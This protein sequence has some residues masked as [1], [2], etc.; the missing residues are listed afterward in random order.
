MDSAS[1]N[2]SLPT[3]G[4][5]LLSVRDADKKRAVQVARDL[6]QLGFKLYAT[7]GTAV[8]IQEAGIDCERVNK[9]ME[10][11]PHLV[12]M[13]KNNEV[14]LIINTTEGKQAL[15]DSSSMYITIQEMSAT[16]G[17]MLMV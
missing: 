14:T 2:S 3:S 6:L 1:I 9:V 16:I 11:R 7:G 15:Q 17:Q 12:D 4:N 5:A 13:I 8:A 10:G